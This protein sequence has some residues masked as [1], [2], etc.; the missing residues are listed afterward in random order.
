MPVE[1]SEKT[2]LQLTVIAMLV[3]LVSGFY[4]LFQAGFDRLDLTGS[5]F[6]TFSLTIATVALV[7]SFK[8]ASYAAVFA[9]LALL[10]AIMV[11]GTCVLGWRILGLTC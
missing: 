7:L 8:N 10:L 6:F 1:E 9:A 5:M 3:V 2:A 11:F 4:S